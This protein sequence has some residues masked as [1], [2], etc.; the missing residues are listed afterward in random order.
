MFSVFLFHNLR[1]FDTLSDWHVKN[2]TTD[3]TATYITGFMSIWM[4]P[5]FFI[6]AGGS[7]FYALKVRTAGQFIKERMLRLIVPLVFGM[8]IIV[9]PQAYYEAISHGWIP[10][11]SNLLELYPT[12]LATLPQLRWFHLWFLAFL[13]IFSVIALPFML[14]GKKAGISILSR[15]A[16]ALSNPWVLLIL[17]GLLLGAVDILMRPSG[18]F[19]SRDSGGWDFVTYLFFYIYGYL[20]FSSPRVI[21]TIKKHGWTALVLAAIAT[22][23]MVMVFLQVSLDPGKNFGTMNYDIAQVLRGV[24]SWSW[25][26]VIIN[27]GARLLNRSNRFL[28]YASDAVLPFYILHQTVIICVG[29]YVVPWALPIA[30]KYL[31]ISTT[32]FI[33]I[34]AI[35]EF[36]VRRIGVLR[37]LFGMRARQKP[38][39]VTASSNT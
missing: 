23:L 31:I 20:I 22:V 35:Y 33:V 7:T 13:F 16:G 15:A 6:L 39:V 3:A 1:F 27:L 34:M 5:L 2:G 30:A 12:Y 11:G 36:L 26:I 38:A 18:F 24:A 25:L 28:V 37:F 4:M 29:F 9:V 19:G 17:P 8:L 10:A 21:K 32:S 14:T